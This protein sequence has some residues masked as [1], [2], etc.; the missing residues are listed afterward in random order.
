MNYRLIS[1]VVANSKYLPQSWNNYIDYS[2]DD[3][4]MAHHRSYITSTTDKHDPEPESE[5]GSEKIEVRLT[6]S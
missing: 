4:I 5:C 1:P 2:E 6:N 3:A